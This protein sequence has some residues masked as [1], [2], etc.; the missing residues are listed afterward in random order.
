[1]VRRTGHQMVTVV[2]YVAPWLDASKSDRVPT[3]LVDNFGV[4]AARWEKSFARI[5]PLMPLVMAGSASLNRSGSVVEVHIENHD[6][7]AAF[8][9]FLRA[10]GEQRLPFSLRRFRY[11]K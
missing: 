7:K 9:C 4:S 5:M 11:S 6:A 8:V 2:S 3:G 10:P 1:M